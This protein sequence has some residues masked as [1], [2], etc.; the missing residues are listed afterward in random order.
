MCECAQRFIAPRKPVSSLCTAALCPRPCMWSSGRLLACRAPS[1]MR[2]LPVE[3]G[4]GVALL[5]LLCRSD[6]RQLGALL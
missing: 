4:G 1:S 6:A 3:C 5:G 2:A